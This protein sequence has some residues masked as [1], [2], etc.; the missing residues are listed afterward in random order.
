M[1]KKVGIGVMVFFVV[2]GVAYFV[3]EIVIGQFDVAFYQVYV[4][5]FAAVYGVF[6][7]AESFHKHGI[8]KYYRPEM[9]D[10]HP[11]VQ[12]AAI[13]KVKNGK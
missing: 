9:D 11:E 6:A 13:E 7:G 5:S 10:R 12:K 1:G 4:G 8:S 3:R 2:F